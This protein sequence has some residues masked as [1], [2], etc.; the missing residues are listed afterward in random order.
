MSQHVKE[1]LLIPSENL[2]IISHVKILT[3]PFSRSFPVVLSFFPRFETTKLW[4]HNVRTSYPLLVLGFSAPLILSDFV[5]AIIQLLQ[6]LAL[7][8]QYG[9]FNTILDNKKISLFPSVNYQHTIFISSI[10]H[11][12]IGWN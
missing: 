4:L 9:Q 7:Q 12:K 10:H 2:P 5:D 11:I 8:G 6:R 3:S 1:L